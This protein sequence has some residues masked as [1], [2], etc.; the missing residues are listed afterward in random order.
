MAGDSL[1][2]AQVYTEFET[3][4]LGE[5]EKG[6]RALKNTLG[7]VRTLL[8]G[9]VGGIALKSVAKSFVVA[10]ARA[11]DYRTSIRAVSSS[12]EEADATF[13]RVK[14]WAAVNPINTDEAIGA[15]VRLRTAA[16]QNSEEAL[17]AIADVATAM[18]RDMREVA[19]AVVT[20]EVEPLRNLGIMLDRTGKKAVLSSNGIR[21]EVSKDIN[22]IRAG[23]I[24]LM[25]KSMGGAMDKAKTTWSG[26]LATM[27][28]M[29]ANFKTDIMGEGKDSGPFQKIKDQIN[30]INSEWE[31][32][33]KSDSYK[34]LIEN[35]QS[36]IVYGI[37][38]AVDGVKKLGEAFR[39]A[40]DHAAELKTA[41]IAFATYQG[42]LAVA[43][44]LSKFN[45]Q[46]TLGMALIPGAT[47]LVS[48]M[49]AAYTMASI[50]IATAG[51][52]MGV[53]KAAILGAT[54]A[55]K[56]FLATIGPVGWATL[57][58]AA[59]YWFNLR[60]EM[61]ETARLAKIADDA[62]AKVNKTFATADASTIKRQ[63]EYVRKELILVSQA[64]IKTQEEMLKLSTVKFMFKEGVLGG[65]GGA[66]SAITKSGLRE[67]NDLLTKLKAEEAELQR[68]YEAAVS[69]E[70]G[71][72][73]NKIP[74]AN[75]DKSKSGKGKSAAEKLVESIRDQIKY[76]NADG[77]SFLPVLDAWLS[78]T[79]VLSDDW[80]ALKDLYN[81]ITDAAEANNPFAPDKVLERLKETK[82]RMASLRE[83]SERLKQAFY[84]T[85]SWQHDM[86][87]ISDAE[88]VEKLRENFERLKEEYISTGAAIE[89]YQLWPQ[90]LKDAYSAL[91]HGIASEAQPAIEMLNKRFQ[92][93]VLTFGEYREALNALLVQYGATP[94]LAK[95]IAEQIKAAESSTLSFRDSI[96][97]MLTDAQKS[98]E[99][100][101]S[102]V[103]GGVVDSFA[104]AIA[105]S[106]NL[107]DA[108]KKLG[109]DIVYTVTKMLLLQQISSW[110]GVGGGS[111]STASLYP[112]SGMWIGAI[113][114]QGFGFHS[115]GV[116]G[117]GGT[118]V[119]ILPKYHAGGV[120][121]GNWRIKPDEEV[122]LLRK[123]EVVLTEADADRLRAG[124]VLGPEGEVKGD[125]VA[126]RLKAA[127]AKLVFPE[128]LPKY[129]AGG[130]VGGIATPLR[131]DLAALSG[132]SASRA[133]DVSF[134]NTVFAPSIIVHVTNNNSGGGEMSDKQAQ[135]LGEG[136]RDMVDARFME[137]MYQF[138]RSGAY[139]SRW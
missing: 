137:N 129:H 114:G 58:V 100:L 108:L 21:L 126:D 139:R 135:Q 57:A 5:T 95:Q 54:A 64:A 46:L 128:G 8:A 107:G 14:N 94:L 72:N 102:A 65:V 60:N 18:H 52:T 33:T 74:A 29:W 109:Q 116:V 3:R 86:G 36:G 103:I 71:G 9:I 13:Q 66:V 93:G 136:V 90:E 68:L 101:A 42:G 27:G 78:K 85:F 22:S 120:V 15:F 45:A 32:F 39:F 2:V 91:H 76:L 131:A 44:M 40:K 43:S 6:I 31:K 82:E 98:F 133:G 61:K 124:G 130:V 20:T 34:E 55:F 47:S 119:T 59:G 122:A 77:E 123:N 62:V 23:I 48:K 118:P 88:H 80:K 134:G 89:N 110:F 117:S 11:E 112:N 138:Q 115:G 84:D 121:G 104:R 30:A 19:A 17:R 125:S 28:G 92:E 10:A 1:R 38:L 105:Y 79:K 12:I 67:N 35:I 69:V 56:T 73:G 97:A 83:E 127:F 4:G 16:V 99:G 63:L 25:T 7:G 70:G 49:G 37:E 75:T 87:L 111:G 50:K 41:V 81:E 53:F 106:E 26:A 113:R 96:R 51:T 132:V 24:E